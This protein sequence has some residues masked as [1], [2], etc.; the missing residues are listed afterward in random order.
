M[1]EKG[2][3]EKLYFLLF[4]SLDAVTAVLMFIIVILNAVNVILRYF[5]NAPLFW[6]EEVTTILFTWTCVLG[7]AI[8]EKWDQNIKMDIFVS[9]WPAKARKI[10]DVLVAVL[11]MVVQGFLIY[12]CFNLAASAQGATP[13][14]K[15]SYGVTYAS[16]VVAG[17]F[18]IWFLIMRI[19]H[20]F[21]GK[22]S[23]LASNP[24]DDAK[25]EALMSTAFDAN[26]FEEVENS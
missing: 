7:A 26:L 5:F 6:A 14:F 13:I 22:P 9:A 1:R 24:E 23:N 11:C 18:S 10:V 12:T 2:I 20:I 17:C 8:V 21:Q 25:I 3:L 4:H 15:I 16:F 19:V